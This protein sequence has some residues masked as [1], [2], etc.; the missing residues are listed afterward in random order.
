MSPLLETLAGDSVRGYG[1]FSPSATT[2]NFTS[3]QTVTVGA[4]GSSS[5]SFSSIPSTY[6]HLQIRGISRST[7]AGSGDGNSIQLNG[8]SGNNY[9]YHLLIGNGSAASAGANTSYSSM[10]IGDTTGS[11]STAGMFGTF[12]VDLLDYTNT[13]KYKT[14]RTLN[15][16]DQNGSG[17]VRFVS[18][19]WQNTAAV[20]SLTINSFNSAGF[21]QYSQFALYGVK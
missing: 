3:I 18:G 20:S 5:I 17:S 9:A 10:Y 6:T 4:G 11:T 13:N 2:G 15:G 7:Y 12:I 21:A 16:N 8:D 19:L 14:I 1:M